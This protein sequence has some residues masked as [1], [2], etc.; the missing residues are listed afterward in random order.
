MLSPRVGC[1][2]RA[3]ADNRE[4]E[5]GDRDAK[6]LR[7]SRKRYIQPNQISGTKVLRTVV[8]GRVVYDDG[9]LKN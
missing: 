7:Y 2:Y 5:R 6:A 8:G 9:E 1:R 3:A 4:I